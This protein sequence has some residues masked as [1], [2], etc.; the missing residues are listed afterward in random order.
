MRRLADEIEEDHQTLS[1]LM[2]TLGTSKNPVKQATTWLAEKASRVK[3]SG[4]SSGE[5]ELGTLLALET[6]SL[7]VEG[8][9]RLWIALKQVQGRSCSR[10]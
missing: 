10:L 8:K 1:E 2:E 7:G 5:D 9:K 3:L 4:M 6:L